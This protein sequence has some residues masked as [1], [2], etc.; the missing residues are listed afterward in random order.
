MIY[1]FPMSL[2]TCESP[3][4]KKLL[5]ELSGLSVYQMAQLDPNYLTLSFSGE[6]SQE[7]I[8]T[9]EQCMGTH[10]PTQVPSHDKF[11][12]ITPGVQSTS[13]P[14][15]EK[16]SVFKHDLTTTINYIET[17]SYSKDGNS[18]DIKVEDSAGNPVAQ[19]LNLSNIEMQVVDLGTIT[20]PTTNICIL[21]MQTTGTANIDSI[22]IYI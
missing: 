8:T 17:I 11:Y 9:I 19:K 4:W 6:L 14:T 22:I 13:S 7:Q 21:Y 3:N 20:Q 16:I 10:T 5:N 12:T 18:Y 1:Q 15:W 2:F